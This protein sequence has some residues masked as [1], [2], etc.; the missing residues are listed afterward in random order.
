MLNH[1]LVTR[2]NCK[3]TITIFLFRNIHGNSKSPARNCK[4]PLTNIVFV[5]TI[6]RIYYEYTYFYY[7][8]S[9][10]FGFS[11]GSP[12][13]YNIRCPI[14]TRTQAWVFRMSMQDKFSVLL[15][16]KNKRLILAGNEK[17]MKNDSEKKNENETHLYKCTY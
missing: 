15:L 9:I 10:S 14:M 6:K 11:A 2:I 4:T 16:A 12:V 7:T 5:F 3:N 1:F 17:V 13:V 8:S